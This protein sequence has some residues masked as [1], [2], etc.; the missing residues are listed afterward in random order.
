MLLALTT[1]V[2]AETATPADFTDSLVAVVPGPTALTFT[3]D[4]RM[5][6]ATQLGQLR[7]LSDD[8]LLPAPAIDLASSLCTGEEQG[9]LGVAVDASFPTDGFV[10]LY[11]THANGG[12]CENRVSRFIMSGNTLDPASELVLVDGIPSPA[13]IHN[14]GDLHFGNDGL[15]YISVGDGGCDYLGDSGC[16]GANDASRDQNVLLGK[17]I[18]VTATGAIPAS[19]PFQGAGTARCNVT[20]RTSAG[21]KCQ[22]TFAWGLRNPFRIA[23]DPNT[24]ATRFFI[25]DVGQSLWEEIDEG[26]AGADYGWNVREGPCCGSPGPEMTDPI[27]SYDHSSGCGAITGGAFVPGGV[28]PSS[29]DGAYVYADYVCGELFLL[30]KGTG[31]S[32][33]A[34][35]FATGNGAPV[36]VA[37]GPYGATQALYYTNYDSGGQIRRIVYTGS[38]NRA[39]TASLTASPSAGPAPL[40]VTFDASGSAD[41]DAGD[42][43]SFR[44]S[45]GDGSPD[46]QTAGPTTQH[47]YSA[48]GTF[49]ATVVAVDNHNAASQPVATRIDSGDSP[50]VPSIDAPSATF[51][52]KVGQVIQLRGSATDPEDGT[53]AGSSLSWTVLKHHNTHTH[54][55]LPP[56]SGSAVDIVGPEPEDAAAAANSY[57]EVILTATDSRGLSRTTSMDILPSKVNVNLATSPAGLPLELFGQPAPSSFIGWE[58]WQLTLNAP[59]GYDANGKNWVFS[60]WSD[61]G[62]RSHVAVVPGVDATYTATFVAGPGP[63]GLA[64]AYGFDENT[65]TAIGDSSGKLNNGTTAGTTWAPGKYGSALSFNGSSSRVTIPDSPS[66]DLTRALTLEAWVKPTTVSGWR[67]VAM[68]ERTGGILYSLYAGESG[69][70]PLGQVDNGAEQNAAGTAS[71]PTNTWSHLAVTW[72]G[73]TLRLYVGGV[74]VASK[75]VTGS[76][77]VSTAPFRIGGNGIW[78]EYFSGA[79]DEVRVYDHA[80]T[81]TEIQADMSR[82]VGSGGG[83]PA[84]TVAPS[85]PGTPSVSVSGSSVTLAWVASTDN[86]GVARYHVYRSTVSGFTPSASNQLATPASAG[87]TDAALAAGTYYYKVTAEDAAGNVSAPSGQASAIVS[88]PAPPAGLVAAYGFDENTGTAVGDASGNANNGVAGNAT[89]AAGKFGSALSF[90]GTS[91]RVTVPDANTLDLTRASTI[92]AWVW[93][94]ALSGWATVVLKER[95]GGIV[96]SLYA[97]NGG[98]VPVGQLWTGAERNALGT[99]KLALNA[100]THLAATWDGATLRLYVNGIQTGS[101]AV[102]ATLDASTGPLSIGGNAIWGEFFKGLIDEVRVYDHALGATEIQAD[103]Q[104][105]VSSGGAPP[106]TTPPSAPGTLSAGVSG[107]TVALAWGAATDTGSGVARYRVYRSTTPGFTPSATNQIATPVGTSYSDVNLLAGN[108]YYRVAAEDGVGNVGP[109]TNEAVGAVQSA[110]PAGGLVAAYNF[111]ESSGSAVNDKSGLGNTGTAT[112]GPLRVPGHTAGSLSF[113]GIDD[114]VS[115]PNSASLSLTTGLTLEAWVKPSQLGST[116]RTVALKERPGGMCWA[117]YAHDSNGTAAHIVTAT[118]STAN[119]GRLTLNTWTHL[120]ATYDGSVLA[121]YR[122]GSLV[123]S[124]L[125]SGALVTSTGALKIGGNSIWSEPFA[126]VLDDLRVYNRALTASEIASDMQRPV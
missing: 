83:Q 61:G 39:P 49:T 21:L 5:L 118:T 120:A 100:W 36:E 72:D 1:A 109:T 73:A 86:V 44:W 104:R 96:Y 99:S 63:P 103:M 47:V 25:N 74:P 20:G 7:V 46:V 54:P 78:G 23:F 37:F 114:V 110:P 98:N 45:F 123:S 112:G 57:L 81:Q 55:F 29:Y 82:P 35:S 106:D 113:D 30:R 42:T 71:L 17:I 27:Y 69:S 9:L 67:S 108:Y 10:Y 19:N 125:A 105:A 26:Q 12:T 51:R 77:A 13:G 14:A 93:P 89:W 28:W 43:I 124:T 111:D 66:L 76:L 11:Y 121:L 116:W 56:T 101:A 84:D 50:P 40:G 122:D 3:P 16:G 62:A 119:G 41:P 97:D 87:Y 2:P 33:S 117:L 65:G 59:D 91:S 38:A 90:N 32:Y 60:S 52:F 75:A 22:E 24:T 31:S 79:I 58:G 18:R 88:S 15:L 102:N 8:T 6:V 80:L 92:E 107:N 53:L 34:S 85:V 64:A 70:K 115:V 94:T 48:V 126:G 4:G 95:T 68:K